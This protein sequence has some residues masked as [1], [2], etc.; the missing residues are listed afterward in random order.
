MLRDAQ[1]LRAEARRSR[2]SW[3][4][5]GNDRWTVCL[6]ARSGPAARRGP[7][8]RQSP[9]FA[10]ARDDARAGFVMRSHAHRRLGMRFH[11]GLDSSGGPARCWSRARVDGSCAGATGA[12]AIEIEAVGCVV[13]QLVVFILRAGRTPPPPRR[14]AT[15]P[16]KARSSGR[17]RELGIVPMNSREFAGYAGGVSPLGSRVIFSVA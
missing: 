1:R 3:A 6:T 4:S 7:K 14:R 5:G 13:D 11:C 15:R 12:A 9:N 2:V 10:Q 17:E 8:R 16:E